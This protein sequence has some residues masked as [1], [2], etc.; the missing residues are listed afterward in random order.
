MFDKY[1]ILLIKE[2]EL[3]ELKEEY[4][5][6]SKENQEN[7][8]DLDKIQRE[9]DKLKSQL[10]QQKLIASQF[11]E[12]YRYELEKSKKFQQEILNYQSELTLE[13]SGKSNTIYKIQLGLF[14]EEIDVEGLD[15]LTKIDT[16]NNQF[17]YLS[18]GFD[19]YSLAR[20]YLIKVNELGFNNAFIVKF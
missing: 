19:S 2:K 3:G 18:G 12:S 15:D 7:L 14:D 10:D 1:S 5:S 13:S 9:N 20:T 17:I 16:E 11:A 4:T 6:L 8:S